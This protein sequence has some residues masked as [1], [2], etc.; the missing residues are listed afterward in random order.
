MIGL[1]C[2]LHRQLD[3]RQHTAGFSNVALQSTTAASS[4]LPFRIVDFYSAFA[5]PA[6]RQHR[7]HRVHQRHRQHQPANMVIVRLNNCDR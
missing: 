6:S 5:P 1:K 7:H 2:R 3:D 4:S